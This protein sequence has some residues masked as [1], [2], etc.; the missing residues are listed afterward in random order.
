MVMR[1]DWAFT[2]DGDLA[3]GEPQLDSNGLKLY[4]HMNGSIDTVKGMDGKEIR[5]LALSLSSSA[6]KQIIMNRL[7]TDAPDWFHHPAMGGNLSDLVGEPNTKDTGFRGATLIKAALT[8][9]NLYSASQVDVR[10]IP[11]SQIEMMF[12]ITITKYQAEPY[13]LP[14]VFNLEHGLLKIYGE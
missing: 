13:Q 6:E 8:Y 4:K 3:L 5:D 2:D 7:K 9:D 11:I 14:L 10:P 1:V 12:F